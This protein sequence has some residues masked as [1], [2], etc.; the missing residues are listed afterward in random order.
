MEHDQKEYDKKEHIIKNISGYALIPREKFSLILPKDHIR[1]IGNDGHFRMGGFVWVTKTDNNDRKYWL[2]GQKQNWSSVKNGKSV[3][4]PLYWDS[5]KYL[6]KK[7]SAETD[8]LRAS[9]DKKQLA[10]NDIV[11]FLLFKYG[12]EFK[13]FME[14]RERKRKNIKS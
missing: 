3:K 11:H 10:I 6:W 4:F 14:D 9:I 13:N 7:M 12:D 5:I 2:I 8:L 1:Y